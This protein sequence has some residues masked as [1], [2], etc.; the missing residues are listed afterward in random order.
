MNLKVRGNFSSTDIIDVHFIVK[1]G[2]KSTFSRGCAEIYR[3]SFSPSPSLTVFVSSF[4]SAAFNLTAEDVVTV[5][6][7]VH[8]GTMWD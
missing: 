7:N 2:L 1:D 3:H 6:I 5:V 4:L 8:P